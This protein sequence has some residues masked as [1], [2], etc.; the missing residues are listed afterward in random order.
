MAVEY[1]RAL[2]LGAA[3]SG[4]DESAL[5]AALEAS[6]VVVS[7]DPT[8]PASP[9]TAH[10]LLTT[11][12]R[13]PGELIL[14]RDGLP[15]RL[16]DELA[17]AVDAV[18]PERPLVVARGHDPTVR[19][20]VGANCA[21]RTVRLVP[22]GHGAHVAGQRTA[23]IR[24]TRPPSAL[25]AVYTAALGA[26]EAFKYTARVLPDRRVLHR[27]LRFCPVSL[28]SDLT[29]APLLAEPV[30]LNL[31][32][33]GVGA[34]G[35]GVVLL[36]AA[37]G[38]EGRLV[39]VDY[40]PFGAENRGTYSLGGAAEMAAEPLKV[41]LAVWALPRFDVVPFPKRVENLTEAIDSGEVPWFPLVVA[42]LDTAEARR[43]TQRL[44]PD[45]LIDAA[46]GDTMLGIHDHVYDAGPC[47]DCFFPEE[48]G[49]PSAAERLAELT[50]IPAE[51]L[52]RGDEPLTEAD[53]TG[54]DEE[55]RTRLA[56][57]LGKPVCGLAQAF[58][59]SALDGAGYQPAVPFVS[60]QAAALAVGRVV[61]ARTGLSGLSNLVQYDGLF[62]PQTA[63]L[64][65]MTAVPECYCQKRATTIAKV[66]AGRSSAYDA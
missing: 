44:W 64:D 1:S 29:A 5:K 20:H 16:V 61:A 34:I 28:S 19:L 7:I 58:G 41:D 14:E 36:L 26:A 13:L 46:T 50:G 24:P 51:R 65:D 42:G 15:T 10:V 54:V 45:R 57:H 43:A 37:L 4:R 27:H 59:L 12:R 11:L 56:H 53:L 66:R 31:T 8:L 30:E 63:T 25:G 23:V 32:L 18:D 21:D 22:D 48:R 17:A 60:L 62:G 49:G 3:A 39:A 35:T 6:R 47:M 33:V 55:M 9:L 52:M 40:Q 2:L 38:A